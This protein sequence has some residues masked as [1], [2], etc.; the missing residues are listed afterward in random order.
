MT[1][2]WLAWAMRIRI[3]PMG[4]MGRIKNKGVRVGKDTNIQW[5]DHSWS[6]WLGC[7][8]VSE[9]CENCYIVETTPF[10]TRDLTHGPVRLELSEFKFQI[11]KLAAPAV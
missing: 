6:P 7:R 3:G 10:R 9:E 8:K 4:R 5:T 1:G 2:S 11:S